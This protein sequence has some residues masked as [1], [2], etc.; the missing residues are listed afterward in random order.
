MIDLITLSDLEQ[1]LSSDCASCRYV[2]G[3]SAG[4]YDID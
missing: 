2:V 3:T 1:L 4:K